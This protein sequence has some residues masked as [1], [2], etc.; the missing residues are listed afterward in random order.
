MKDWKVIKGIYESNIEYMLKDKFIVIGTILCTII[1]TIIGTH[2][3]YKKKIED[4]N[5][6]KQSVGED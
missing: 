3:E 4:E 2:I 6:K 1:G 5:L